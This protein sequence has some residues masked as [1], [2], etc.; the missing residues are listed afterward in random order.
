M[1]FNPKQFTTFKLLV[2]G[3]AVQ[4]GVDKFFINTQGPTELLYLVISETAVI[5]AVIFRHHPLVLQI[6]HSTGLF[7]PLSPSL[8]IQV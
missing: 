8:N 3:V 2:Q 5:R 6:A 1:F 4:C 7:K